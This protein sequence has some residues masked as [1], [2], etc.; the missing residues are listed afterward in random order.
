MTAPAIKRPPAHWDR[1]PDSP[2]L[3]GIERWRYSG[4]VVTS[5][6]AEME[7]PDGTHDV[8]ETWLVAISR[9]GR[10]ASDEDVRRALRAFGMED[11]LEDNHHPGISRAFF[12][13]VDPARRR[14]CECKLGEKLITEADGY[15][16]SND[17]K[18]CRGCEYARLFGTPCPIHQPQRTAP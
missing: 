15:Q 8:I 7:A 4:F 3:R 13:P 17:T 18:E 2:L 14:E 9:N 16:W 6:L 10:R 12:L 5:Q 1:M 11:A